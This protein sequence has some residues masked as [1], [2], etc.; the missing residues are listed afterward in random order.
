MRRIP[1]IRCSRIVAQLA[2]PLALALAL[3]TLPDAAGAERA[4]DMPAQPA[5]GSGP[6]PDAP[7]G[8]RR[9]P[10]P[11]EDL[12]E[13]NA[14]RL[15]LDEKTRAEIRSIA[16]AT[17][18]KSRPLQQSLRSLRDE[19]RTLLDQAAP[20][21]EAVFQQAERIGAAETAL[22]KLRLESMLEIRSLLTPAQRE[23]LVR[24]HEERRR[25]RGHGGPPAPPQPGDDARGAPHPGSDGE[26]SPSR[27][28]PPPPGD[29]PPDGW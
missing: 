20:D 7:R 6:A 8:P 10:P 25:A 27:M 11:F 16:D 5:G 18:E 4:P 28:L 24:I 21:H 29:P 14:G 19:M 22:H 12:L 17:R 13:R 15:G 3:L 26:G 2:V 1:A 9:G 23:E